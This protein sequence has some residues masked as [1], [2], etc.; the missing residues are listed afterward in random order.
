MRAPGRKGGGVAS[1]R[2][3]SLSPVPGTLSIDRGRVLAGRCAIA[4]RP[5]ARLVGLLGTPDLG[6]HEALV[7]MPC[8]AVHGIG[9]RVRIGVAF[10]DGRGR[11]LRVVDPLPRRGARCRGARAV[12]EARS[13]VLRVRPGDEMRVGGAPLFPHGGN[14]ASRGRGSTGGARALSGHRGHTAP[15]DDRRQ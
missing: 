4:R 5:L 8:N 1:C 3:D 10:V 14:F 7:L 6:P 11:V 12:I 2:F 13:G 15:D 9:L